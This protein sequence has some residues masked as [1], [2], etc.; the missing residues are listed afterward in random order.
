MTIRGRTLTSRQNEALNAIRDHIRRKSVPPSRAEL[1]KALGLKNPSAVDQI[2]NALSKKG[3]LRLHTGIERG[4]ELLRE[5]FPLI[6]LEDYPKLVAGNPNAPEDYPEPQRLDR[7]DKYDD[8]FSNVFGSRPDYFL[9]V[10]DDSMDRVVRS[11]DVVAMRESRKARNGDIVVTRIGG[12][13]TLRRF[14]R[15]DRNAV[16]LRPDSSNPGH[17]PIRAS[18]QGSDFE[19]MGVIIGAIVATAGEQTTEEE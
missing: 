18:A 7:P 14:Y 12:E 6:E 4:I 11:G 1:A 3:W 5:G 17:E 10:R 19:I 16:E 8:L 15:K 13:I 9:K 2:L